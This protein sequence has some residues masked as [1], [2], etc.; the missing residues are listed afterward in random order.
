MCLEPDRPQQWANAGVALAARADASSSQAGAPECC[1]ALCALDACSRQGRRPTR[2]C[3]S[4][5]EAWSL[6]RP[7]VVGGGWARTNTV[8]GWMGGWVL[9][10][11]SVL[12][13]PL[14]LVPI[15]VC[16]A[17][18]SVLSGCFGATIHGT[19]RPRPQTAQSRRSRTHRMSTTR[20]ADF[21]SC[22]RLWAHVLVLPHGGKTR[23]RRHGR[24]VWNHCSPTRHKHR[25]AGSAIA[26]YSGER[27][28]SCHL[29]MLAGL[30]ILAWAFVRQHGRRCLALRPTHGIDASSDIH[31]CRCHRLQRIDQRSA[32]FARPR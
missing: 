14:F 23:W 30:R 31:R 7:G 19:L 15:T 21:V 17:A 3:W 5:G 29:F 27:R 11:A 25:T 10:L 32:V 26:S 6:G 8:G 20:R 9:V 18:C 16:W 1:S 2:C 4:L 24:E 13:L 12:S 28:P 22:W